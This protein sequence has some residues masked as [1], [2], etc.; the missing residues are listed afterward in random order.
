MHRSKGGITTDLSNVWSGLTPQERRSTRVPRCPS[1]SAKVPFKSTTRL[2]MR[3][4]PRFRATSIDRWISLLRQ[5]RL[6]ERS[7]LL[8]DAH[9]RLLEYHAEALAAAGVDPD[10]IPAPTHAIVGHWVTGSP[11]AAGVGSFQ[12]NDQDRALVRAPI[13]KHDVYVANVDYG[14]TPGWAVGSL[15]M[16]EKVLQAELGLAAPSWLDKAW[17]EQNIINTP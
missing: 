13:H 17:Y 6:S 10:S 9:R 2:P 16:M 12:G 11:Y 3:T 1:E 14:Y 7:R 15:R 5:T 8:T 4:I